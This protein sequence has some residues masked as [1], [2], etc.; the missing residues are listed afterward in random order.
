MINIEAQEKGVSDY[1][2]NEFVNIIVNKGTFRVVTRQKMDDLQGELDFNMSGSVS[3]NTAQ[4][5]GALVGAD[6]LITGSITPIA[7]AYR[8]NI[9]ALKTAT[10][11]IMAAYGYDVK[12]DDSRISGLANNTNSK[13]IEIRGTEPINRNSHNFVQLREYAKFLIGGEFYVLIGRANWYQVWSD[14]NTGV[15]LY[16]EATGETVVTYVAVH[17]NPKTGEVLNIVVVD[18]QGRDVPETH[19]LTGGFSADEY[20]E[21]K[22]W[23]EAIR[24]IQQNEI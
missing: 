16:I 24:Y 11:E 10:G 20:F 18:R 23:M 8:L 15:R 1:I 3:D 6:V 19:E 5:I 12:S 7:N 9:Q 17:V 13:P 22:T 2:I 14:R 21:T 4:S